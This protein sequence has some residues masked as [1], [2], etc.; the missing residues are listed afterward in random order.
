MTESLT[1][2]AT[3][4]AFIEAVTLLARYVKQENEDEHAAERYRLLNGA[5]EAGETYAADQYEKG[6]DQGYHEAEEDYV[7]GHWDD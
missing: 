7:N 4:K 3:Q 5:I 2:P 6:H 1:A